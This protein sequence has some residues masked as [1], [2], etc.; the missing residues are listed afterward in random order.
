[1]IKF[2]LTKNPKKLRIKLIYMKLLFRVNEENKNLI[3]PE[4]PLACK[5]YVTKCESRLN[6]RL[7]GSFANC[8]P[9]FDSK[10]LEL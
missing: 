10:K 5:L 1:M 2:H 8:S 4:K 7:L 9:N 6:S 3:S